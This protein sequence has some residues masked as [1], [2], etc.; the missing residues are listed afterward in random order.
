MT[1]SLYGSLVT[2]C[3]LNNLN[4]LCTVWLIFILTFNHNYSIF[5]F[6]LFCN[7]LGSYGSES[8]SAGRVTCLA[9]LKNSLFINYLKI[10]QSETLVKCNWSKTLCRNSKD[11]L[12][13]SNMSLLLYYIICVICIWKK[14]KYCISKMKQV[15]QKLKDNLFICSFK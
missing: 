14:L 10:H 12:T 1:W 8:Y 4:W 13:F 15:N 7:V 3:A 9:G 11:I 6:S 5:I 2:I